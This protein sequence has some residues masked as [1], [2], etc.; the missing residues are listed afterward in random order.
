VQDAGSTDQLSI[1]SVWP[2]SSSFELPSMQ[3]ALLS[4][5]HVSNEFDPV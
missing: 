4:V 1:A 5:P 2:G 3:P